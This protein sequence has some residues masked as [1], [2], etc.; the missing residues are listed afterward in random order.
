METKTPT[1]DISLKY[2]NNFQEEDLTIPQ[3]Q[4]FIKNYSQIKIS[5]I[6]KIPGNE[7]KYQYF[8]YS[9]FSFIYIALGIVCNIIPYSY[10]TPKFI[11][12]NSE[13]FEFE[14]SHKIACDLKNFR[15]EKQRESLIT[16]F[17]L[18]CGE[19]FRFIN[20]SQLVIFIGS[21]VI[22]LFVVLFSG[23]LGKRK[24]FFFI[25]FLFIFG[26]GNGILFDDFY[27]I[28]F[29]IVIVKSGVLA[30]HSIAN[31][32]VNEICSDFLRSKYMFFDFIS[33]IA[34]IFINFVL[35]YIEGYKNFF[36]LCFLI[37]IFF[38]AFF[39]RIIE[40]PFYTYFTNDVKNFYLNLSQISQFNEKDKTTTHLQ[41]SQK[42]FLPTI[43]TQKIQTV[44]YIKITQK[45]KNHYKSI[46]KILFN[47]FSP[48]N[49]QKLF[50]SFFFI[51]NLYINNCISRTMP[52]KLGY[53]NIYLMNT[54]FSICDL[55]GFI[56]ILPIS[57][58]VKRRK[59]NIY[60]NLIFICIFFFLLLNEK[61]HQKNSESYVFSATFLSCFL[62]VV[63]R[64]TSSL[65][66]N[67]IGELFDTSVRGVA[68]GVIITLGRVSEAFAGF[69]YELSVFYDIHP[70]IIT[71]LPAFFALPA[72]YFLPETVG[73]GLSN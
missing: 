30:F 54:L 55:I 40:S 31:L 17:D 70:L 10:Y 9:L 44:E 53:D 26:L 32:Y 62:M 56:I 15:I 49:L 19:D 14:C 18:Y 33:A 8:I 6:L 21:A 12:K 27:G 47:L 11:C 51:I 59:L 25:L 68:L 7:G 46:L 58:V 45:Q 4:K 13:N 20:K 48:K 67:Y 35:I 28:V 61:I 34:S 16:E 42:L 38:T 1:S 29:G 39:Y 3:K 24:S 63:N 36:I 43:L 37:M 60:S 73:K 69:F 22:S 66:F 2:L 71:C 5:Q 23:F 65:A 41:L 64:M 57:H 72:C 50:L 52:Q